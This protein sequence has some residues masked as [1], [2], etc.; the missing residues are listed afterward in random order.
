MRADRSSSRVQVAAVILTYN[1]ELNISECLESVAD[2]PQEIFVVDSGSTDRT[3]ELCRQ[4]TDHIY[5][6]DF[7]DSA[8]QWNWALYNLPLSWDWILP[9]DADHRLDERLKSEI[10]SIV[11]NPA[12]DINGYFSR[13]QYLFM[14]H[15]IR[16]F[17]NHGLRLFRRSKTRMDTSEM[18]DF[19]FVV[20]GKTANLKGCTFEDNRK[21]ASIDFWIDKHQKFSSRTATEEVLRRVGEVQ[22]TTHPR[23]LGN[24]DE[25][26][27]WLKERWYF[28]PLYVRPFLYFF[29]RYFLR[30]GFLDG[31][32][33]LVYHFLQALWFR[34]LVDIKIADLRK[35]IDSGEVTV[36]ELAGTVATRFASAV[37]ETASGSTSR[38]ANRESTSLKAEPDPG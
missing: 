24:P 35:R 32:T 22:W 13:H 3:I 31:V 19:R 9:L 30:L 27:I 6:H 15:P 25:R 20:D 8:T 11:L 23:L 17:K 7:V 4:Y 14:G 5:T 26:I 28:M 37:S 18:V 29:Y 21:E 38:G 10:R 12:A 16:G 33:G 36:K 2:L 1:E 34:L